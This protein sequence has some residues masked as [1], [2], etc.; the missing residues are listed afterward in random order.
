LIRSCT[1]TC[2]ADTQGWFEI[3]GLHLLDITTLA[4]R[5]AKNYYTAHSQ[6]QRLHSIK[7]ERQIRSEL[8]QV[9]EILKRMATRNFAGGLRQAE[10]VGILTWI[11][12]IS[13]LIQTEIDQEKLEAEE[14][15][16]WVW[17]TGDWTGR[18]RQR[19][20]EFIKSF[21]ENPEALPEWLE[22]SPTDDAALPT[23]FLKY[24]QNGLQLVKLHN[25]LVGKSRRQFEEIKV[26]HT[27]TQKPYRCAENLRFWIKAAQ[28]RW[29]I[30]L[31]VDPAEVMAVVQGTSAAAWRRF[32]G[33]VLL[34]SKGVREELSA[35]WA[36]QVKRVPPRLK[37][38]A[39][40]EVRVPVESSVGRG[41]RRTE[42]HPTTESSERSLSL[43]QATVVGHAV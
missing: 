21:I 9:L 35:E 8:Y 10:K 4:I 30:N 20:Y 29:E 42:S 7:S 25:V 1:L 14:R 6:Y 2:W 41:A 37:V 43:E 17:R 22:P 38:E 36:E 34:W 18:E 39:E 16:K 33:M 40:P 11:V 28:L 32:D 12:G 26:F 31:R 13:E 15:E 3:Q 19:E 24:L 27:D 5:A 23:P